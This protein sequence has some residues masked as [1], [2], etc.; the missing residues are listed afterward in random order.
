MCLVSPS[1]LLLNLGEQKKHYLPFTDDDLCIIYP[2]G[3]L[4]N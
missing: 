3:T 4:G 1:V 2:S